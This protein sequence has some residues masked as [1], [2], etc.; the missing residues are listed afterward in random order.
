MIHSKIRKR[1]LDFFEKRGHKVVPSSSLIPD[2]SSVLFTTAGMQQFKKY[3]INPESAPFKNIVS[4]QKCMRTSD[5]DEVGDETHLTFFE[6]LGN[7]SFGG[8]GKEEAQKLAQKFIKDELGLEIAYVTELDKTDVNR[9][10]ID[11]SGQGLVISGIE[12]SARAWSSINIDIS[13]IKNRS[14]KENFWGP[15]GKEGPCG[16][17]TEIYVNNTDRKPVEIWNLVFNEVYC[18]KDKK[19]KPLQIKGIDTGMGL[20]RLAM[21]VQKKNNIFETDLFEPI[22]KLMPLEFDIRIRRIIADHSRAVTF[23][24]AEG[25]R[26]SNKE[27][28]YVLRRLMRRVITYA[29][30]KNIK[31]PPEIILKKVVELYG[32][33]YPNLDFSVIKRVYDGEYQKFIKS[34]GSG[35]KE[36]EKSSSVDAQTAFKLYENFGLPYE[37][38]K[39]A[40]GEKAKNLSLKAFDEEFKKHQEIS[41]IGAEKKF[42]LK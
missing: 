10:I 1:F 35:L 17:T 42:G 11:L 32:D 24:I 33:I 22:I 15:T 26:P 25:V 27:Q 5:I 41:R 34:V 19:Y 31:T 21:V 40:A 14:F 23:L 28:G 12:S 3:Y 13:K 8:Y 4:I 6:M 18:T 20:E 37:V 16:P 9:N 2:D 7:F 39:E 36:L 38:I 29:Y 30:Q